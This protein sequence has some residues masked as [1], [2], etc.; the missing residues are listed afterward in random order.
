[1]SYLTK[2]DRFK[3]IS[4]FQVTGDESLLRHPLD[5]VPWTSQILML[6]EEDNVL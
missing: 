3:M 4:F 2:N 5:T 1:M 6:L